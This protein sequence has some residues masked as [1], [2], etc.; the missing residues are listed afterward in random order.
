[1]LLIKN[2]YFTQSEKSKKAL[3]LNLS[4]TR[5]GVNKSEN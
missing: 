1:M 2:N 4:G 5:R 3:T